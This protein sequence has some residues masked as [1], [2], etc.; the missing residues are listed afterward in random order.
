[1]TSRRRSVQEAH[2]RF[3]VDQFICEL[4][5]RHRS[6]YRVIDEPNPPEAI[7]QSNRTMSWVEVTTAF[8]FEE[9]A[10]DI[11]SFATEG[12]KHEPIE[13]G[14]FVEPDAQFSS[15]FAA[16]VKKKLEKPSYSNVRDKYG[17]GYLVVFI[18]YP[19]FDRHTL[20]YMQEAWSKVTVTDLK[21]FRSIYLMYRVFN[22]YKLSLWRPQGYRMR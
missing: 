6:N 2:E 14:D 4:N 22:G 16:V 17:P 12:E 5:R 10:K 21:C 3:T 18:Q 11:Y 9:F 1:M 19:A 13:Y 7:I 15:R 8:W 20:R